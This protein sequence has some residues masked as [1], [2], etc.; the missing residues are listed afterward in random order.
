MLAALSA[1]RPKRRAQPAAAPARW[2]WSVDEFHALRE[3]GWFDCCKALLIDGEIVE[4]PIP[5]PR[6]NGSLT[7]ADYALKSTFAV[8]HVVRVQLPLVLGQSTDPMPDLAV[9]AGAP[10]DF[11]DRHPIAAA[12]V[13]E[14]SETSL[15]FDTGE[16]AGLYAAAGIADYWVI[17]L[18]NDRVLVH[19]DSVADP[20]APHRG[21]YRTTTA[22]G[23]SEFL[24]PLANPAAAI[25]AAELLP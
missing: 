23:R 3:E 5:G 13:V 11:L 22:V 6:H 12:L 19:R 9:V 24:R 8:G 10:R 7:L 4:M 20:A 15:S 25:P 18:P 17:D 21:R 1:Q 14:V 2:R 16:K